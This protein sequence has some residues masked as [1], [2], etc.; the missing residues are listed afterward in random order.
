M[1]YL[2]AIRDPGARYRSTDLAARVAVASPHELVAMMIDALRSALLAAEAA[3]R[4][5]RPAQRA[6]SVVKALAIL[7]GLEESLDFGRGGR[8][9]R[10][11]AALYAQVRALAVAGNDEERPELFG[12]AAAQ[13]AALGEA[14]AAIA[15]R[16]QAG[17]R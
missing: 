7:D 5:A 2:A 15:T 8:V 10:A 9:A 3:S 12:G 11:L 1:T 17:I 14:W 13:V 6:K 16:D 4:G